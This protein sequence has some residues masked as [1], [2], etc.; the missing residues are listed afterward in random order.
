[1]PKLNRFK[2]STMRLL[3]GDVESLTTK[4][5]DLV[6]RINNYGGMVHGSQLQFSPAGVA[7]IAVYFD[8][9]TVQLAEYL[10]DVRAER[11]E[12]KKEVEDR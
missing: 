3:F 10:D 1:M 4:Y 2:F 8:I 7:Y 6:N 12:R 11:A 9:P 5:E